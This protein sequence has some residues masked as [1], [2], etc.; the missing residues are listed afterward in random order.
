AAGTGAPPWARDRVT[1]QID[2]EYWVEVESSQRARLIQRQDQYLVDVL[3][4]PPPLPTAGT[5][6]LV[7]KPML[8]IRREDEQV[9][10]GTLVEHNRRIDERPTS[11]I[12]IV[13][14]QRVESRFA[15]EGLLAFDIE[16][17]RAPDAIVPPVVRVTVNVSFPE[18]HDIAPTK[19]LLFQ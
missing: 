15:R 5:Y 6:E 18:G 11:P 17:Q 4:E 13:L 1:V 3:L 16:P 9:E 19:D 8:P 2:L 7:L 10:P 12:A 14:R